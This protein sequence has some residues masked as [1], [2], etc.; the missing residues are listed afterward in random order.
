M[1]PSEQT[2]AVTGAFG[3][4]GR[5]VTRLLLDMGKRVVTLTGHSD[6]NNPFGEQV[7]ALPFDFA[8][9]RKLAD[10]LKGTA[11]LYITYWVRFPHKGMTYEKAVQNTFR[12]IEAAEKANVKRLVYVSISSADKKSPFPYFSGKGRIEE[13]IQQSNLS[14]AIIRP[15]V[16][17]GDEGILIN[18]IAWLLRRLPLFGIFGSGGYKIQPVYVK[19]MARIMVEAGQSAENLIMDAV[20]PETYTFAELVRLIAK[21]INSNARIIPLSPRLGLLIGKLVGPL[22][23]DV[24]ITKDEIYGLM[25]NLLYSKDK[26][27]GTTRLSKWITKNAKTL[28]KTYFGELKKHY[29]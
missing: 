28:G 24:L 26:P 15:T 18:N 27:T 19:D 17:F 7:K 9:P 6:R 10:H 22:V 23:G 4:T 11:T 20:G 16:I 5:Y 21:T 12:L 25:A 29:K 2:D 8:D 3:Y 13:K 14:Y 1:M